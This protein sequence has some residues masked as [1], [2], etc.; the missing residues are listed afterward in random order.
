MMIKKFV[1]GFIFLLGAC[2]L[3]LADESYGFKGQINIIYND[4]KFFRKSPQSAPVIGK[5]KEDYAVRIGCLGMDDCTSK[6]P[7]LYRLLSTKKPLHK[8]CKNPI[9]AS[10]EIQFAASIYGSD[11]ADEKYQIDSS[12]KCVLFDGKYFKL[13]RSVFEIFYENPISDW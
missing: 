5:G 2:D 10:V 1:V 6:I 8:A 7:K 11:K 4:I 12:G 13:K 9:Y 3:C